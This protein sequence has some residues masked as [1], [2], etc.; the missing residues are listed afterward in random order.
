MR[1]VVRNLQQR[2]EVLTGQAKELAGQ[3]LHGEADARL[4]EALDVARQLAEA[5]ED[6]RR[7]QANIDVLRGN[8]EF[9]QG[10]G[11]SAVCHLENAL[12]KYMGLLNVPKLANDDGFIQELTRVLIDNAEIMMAYGDPALA[13]ASADSAWRLYVG[14]YDT[15]GWD[16][17][18]MG[19]I[20]RAASA[21]LGRAGRL[22]DAIAADD[23]VV[24]EARDAAQASG[25]AA[26]RI[27]LAAALAVQGLHFN[28]SGYEGQPAEGD[29]VPVSG[30]AAGLGGDGCRDH[31]VGARAISRA[32][33]DA[34]G[35]A[36]HRRAAARRQAHPDRPA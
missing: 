5:G 34:R 25:S 33:G 21:I 8:L 17:A 28:A 1:R 14:R 27:R 26:D 15:P 31:R 3:G 32:A 7:K 22:D 36:R 19:R 4:Q 9:A 18:Q 16:A 6:A 10:H 23:C 20:A 2:Y 11:A 35:G 13:A 30:P 12:G 29:P 24:M